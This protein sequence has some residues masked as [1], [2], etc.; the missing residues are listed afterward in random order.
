MNSS[1]IEL[2]IQEI[3]SQT[4][5]QLASF[6]SE[7]LADI[8]EDYWREIV[9]PSL[10]YPQKMLVDQKGVTSLDGLDLSA[11]L[12]ILDRNWFDLS[13][14]FNFS[15][16]QRNYLKEMQSIRNRW[17]HKT[18]EKLDLEDYYR[19]LDTIQRFVSFISSNSE[20]K[21]FIQNYKAQLQSLAAEKAEP[22][23]KTEAKN[24]TNFSINEFVCLKS[25]PEKKGVILEID[26]SKEETRYQI[27]IDSKK[28]WFYESQLFR[29]PEKEE[30]NFLTSEEFNSNLSSILIRDPS[31]SKLYSLNSAR[32][33]FI[34]YQF[35]PVLKLMRSDRPRLLIADG[36]GV[37]K[38]I[39]AGLIIKE[40]QARN[41]IESVLIICPKPLITEKKWENE[42]RRF[43]E[44]FSPLDGP[45]MRNCIK[46]TNLEGQWPQQYEKAIIPFSLFDEKLL[47]GSEG[48]KRKRKKQGL[49]D[50]DPPPKFDLVIV[51]EAHKI[52]NQSTYTHQ[53]TRFFCDNA[54]A[55]I[56]LTATPIQLGGNDLFTL[57]NV[58]RPDLVIDENTYQSMIAP[59]PK[60]HKAVS[61]LRAQE[62]DWQS[63]A[64]DLLEQAAHTE[65]GSSVIKNKPEFLEI[66]E[67]LAKNNLSPEQRVDLIRDIEELN[68]FSD[69]I[70]RT[71]R[72]DIG[73]FTVR[74]PKTIE[75]E[76]TPE[77]KKVHDKVLE[78]QADVLSLIHDN[79]NIKF[80]MSTILRQAASCINGLVPFLKDILTRNLSEIEELAF[81]NE[82]DALKIAKI[83]QDIR[84][85]ISKAENLG[86]KDPKLES[87]LKIVSEKQ[88]DENNRIIV[89][90]TFRHTLKY[91]YTNLIE[92]GV[93]VGLV[94]G[95][96][97]VEERIWL[98]ECFEMDR[99]SDDAVDVLLFSE[100]GCEG[101]DYQ[102]CDCMVNYDLPW[103]P[104]KIEQRI[105]RIDRNGQQ[106]EKVLIYNMITKDTVDA[107]IYERCLKRIGVF[108]STLGAGEEI[109]GEISQQIQGIAEDYQL[110]EQQRNDKLQQLADN[111]I[112]EIQE[113]KRLEDR[114]A[115]FFGVNLPQKQIDDEIKHA[116]SLWLSPEAVQ[117]LVTNYIRKAA[118]EMASS[119]FILGEGIEKTLRLSENVRRKLL[120]D[121]RQMPKG[122]STVER[123]WENWLSGDNPMLKITFD[124]R[125]AADKR[126]VTLISPQHPLVRQAAAK[127]EITD[128]PVACLEVCQ[129]GITSGDYPF[130]VYKWVYTGITK[131]TELMPIASS[132][133]VTENLEELLAQACDFDYETQ[134]TDYSLW[135]DIESS[136]YKL[137]S[138][139]RHRHIENV[140]SNAEYKEKS[141]SVSHKARVSRYQDIINNAD[142]DKIIRMRTSELK[143]AEMDYKQKIE[144]IQAAPQRADLNSDIVA[145]GI[146]RVKEC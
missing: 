143:S 24:S 41:K 39:E 10:T 53:A 45:M 144:E 48:K 1:E 139:A 52:K 116:T 85:I 75:A 62:K 44:K 134:I 46:E 123:P 59:N 9:R 109:L 74:E 65:W 29:E 68:T 42:M 64:K 77:Q 35:R 137:W 100:I 126:N 70:N 94:N 4:T 57:L 131:K 8:S 27:F 17:A 133:E 21:E 6:L 117:R 127:L 66:Q 140:R 130:A 98:R 132:K 115:E 23:D 76:F 25:S 31:F 38:T 108:E 124:I 51:D 96:T 61:I 110:T 99:K 19:D 82:W 63:Q 15:K 146:L 142:D 12:R 136:H 111:K 71:R 80:M 128:K 14:E 18:A 101:L 40:L 37:G 145:Y 122:K 33:D 5:V 114:Q 141:L 73:S 36:V 72:R 135:E 88:S 30:I 83:P 50:L 90:S 91:L 67:K 125:C 138:F 22:V 20:L 87:L 54:E 120:E 95:D 84:K 13:G 34:P 78:I 16:E 2:K 49:L 60:I 81:L 28:S 69:M 112:R 43:E 3:L 107:A 89:F 103:N 102:F 56:F 47:Y 55:V 86:S 11:L 106:S 26:D 105:G 93:R 92:N 7:E 119:E 121:Y 32:I 79:Q 129:S 58:I 97:P 113:Q 118:G 104:M